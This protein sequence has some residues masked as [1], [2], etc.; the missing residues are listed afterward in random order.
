MVSFHQDVL[1]VNFIKNG[2]LPTVF[3]ATCRTALKQQGILEVKH[4]SLHESISG[5]AT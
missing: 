1:V 5:A 3:L 2:L 4:G